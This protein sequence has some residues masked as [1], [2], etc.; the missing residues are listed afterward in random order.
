MAMENGRDA[1][2]PEE[3]VAALRAAARPDPGV[4]EGSAREIETPPEP[5][6]SAPESSAAASEPAPPPLPPQEPQPAPRAKFLLPL[7]AAA[8]GAV[9]AYLAV[10]IFDPARSSLDDLSSRVATL[11]G[12]ES[13]ASGAV[14]ALEKRV[15]AMEA[16]QAAAPA[17]AVELAARVAALEKALA[18]QPNAEA[19]LADIAR[20]RADADKALKLAS[21]APPPP[22]LPPAAGGTPSDA[23]LAALS[24]RIAKLEAASAS[25]ASAE[26][27]I[28]ALNQR[29]AKLEAALSA[30]KSE[31]RVALEAHAQPNPAGLLLIAQ[32]LSLSLPAG[33]PFGAEFDA[34]KRLG[35]SDETL[36]ALQP[37]AQSGAPTMAMLAASFEAIAP[38]ILAAEQPKDE[39]L[40]DWIL[41]QLSSLMTVRPKG[42]VAGETVE[43]LV[44]QIRAALA[45]GDIAGAVSVFQRL[46]EAERASA[47]DWGAKAA[48]RAAAD[49]ALAKLRADGLAALV[50][51]KG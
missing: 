41:S 12:G 3:R 40:T 45:E 24:G 19:M 44:S 25:L 11:E 43:A 26:S 51:D 42:A 14:E 10:F 15:G 37:F 5:K 50:G 23:A 31:A 16:A 33:R 20:A 34:L 21:A 36:K 6:A 22:P 9:L 4:I 1:E 8:G 47:K 48:L 27:A 38:D 2:T 28:D 17:A 35:A 49:A 29:V 39:G 46:P 7:L 18:S 32:S 30:P 13:K